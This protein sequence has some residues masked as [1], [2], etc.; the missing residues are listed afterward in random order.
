[1]IRALRLISFPSN[2]KPSLFITDDQHYEV[3]WE[4]EE[5]K[6]IQLELGPEVSE[7]YIESSQSEIQFENDLL[8]SVLAQELST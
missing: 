4:D 8:E 5:G 6:A 3:A 1:M 2:A 7:L